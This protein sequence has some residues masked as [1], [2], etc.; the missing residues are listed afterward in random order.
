M[1]F[2]VFQRVYVV[3]LLDGH[4]MNC[5]TVFVSIYPPLPL[6]LSPHGLCNAVHCGRRSC[7]RWPPVSWRISWRSCR[8]TRY[9]LHHPWHCTIPGIVPSLAPYHP[10]HCTI[11]GITPSLA[12]PYPWHYTIPDT[13]PSL[14]LHY[15]WH[16]NISDS[17]PSLALHYPWH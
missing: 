3:H 7:L 1:L 4:V 13:A 17:L 14:A 11:P 8:K 15:A 9:T 2:D 5:I 6:S 10:W 12:L 16:S